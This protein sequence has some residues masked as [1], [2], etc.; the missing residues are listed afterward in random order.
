MRHLFAAIAFLSLIAACA[1]EAETP[2]PVLAGDLVLTKRLTVQE[3]CER[4]TG[5]YQDIREGAEVLVRDG[6]G[7]VVGIGS[8]E[9]GETG[10]HPEG[11]R[12]FFGFTA[13]LARE[14]DFYTVEIAGRKGPHFSHAGLVESGWKVTL[15]P[16]R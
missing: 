2:P 12:C 15:E 6:A 9:L 3:R 14:A 5:D 16:G 4:G 8:L 11:E 1:T 13:Q 7:A 10:D